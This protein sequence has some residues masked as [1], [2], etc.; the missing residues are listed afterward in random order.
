MIL[1]PS[2]ELVSPD[3][4]PRLWKGGALA[5]HFLPVSAVLVGPWSFQAPKGRDNL[6]QAK[7]LGFQIVTRPSPEGATHE[8]ILQTNCFGRIGKRKTI[9]TGVGAPLQGLAESFLLETRAPPHG[10]GCDIAPLW[11]FPASLPTGW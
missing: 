3:F 6:A 10:L 1:F 7:G 5:P 8:T 2:G 4:S 11:G 9:S